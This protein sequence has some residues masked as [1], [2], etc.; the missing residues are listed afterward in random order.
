M[1]GCVWW[2]ARKVIPSGC[3]LHK[4]CKSVNITECAHASDICIRHIII[5][6]KSNALVGRFNFLS[7]ISRHHKWHRS[8]CLG[9]ISPSTYECLKERRTGVRCVSFSREHDIHFSST[10]II[11]WINCSSRIFS[12]PP[13]K[14]R[15]VS[16]TSIILHFDLV[17]CAWY[18]RQQENLFGRF[19]F[20]LC[21]SCCCA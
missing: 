19:P 12:L 8:E 2:A 1:M 9:K 21:G 4:Y 13:G 11:N 16:T 5:G 15:A 3:L 6:V 17:M 14:C 20:N 10:L 7:G 18:V